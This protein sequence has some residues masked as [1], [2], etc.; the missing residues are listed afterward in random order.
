[1]EEGEI[2]EFISTHRLGEM[3]NRLVIE[4]SEN[5]KAG[6]EINLVTVLDGAKPFSSHLSEGLQGVG[7]CVRDYP[8][9][10]GSYVGKE[11]SGV[12]SLER[13]I[14]GDLSGRDV[15][16]VED[17]V[18]T[19]Q[20][21]KFL[22]EYLSERGVKKTGVVSLFSKPSRRICEVRID[23]LGQEIPDE[24]I[25]GYGMDFDGRYRELDFIGIL[26]IKTS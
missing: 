26:R 14:E 22:E 16:I 8:I 24:F 10:V 19:G 21:I 15:L 3:V 20:T 2:Q 4:I 13:G 9:K 5:S 23:Y 18:D 12:M 25:V 17:I 1:M 7:F 6:S 11:S